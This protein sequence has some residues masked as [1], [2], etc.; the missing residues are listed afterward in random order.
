[1]A[2]QQTLMAERRG[3]VTALSQTHDAAAE[4]GKTALAEKQTLEALCRGEP[5][6]LDWAVT[7]YTPYVAAVISHVVGS[8]AVPADVEE[9]TSD[10]FV[11]LWQQPE[12]VRAGKLRPWLGAVARNKARDFLRSQRIELPLE[13]DLLS[14]ET[15][16]M[17]AS[18]EQGELRQAVRTAVFSMEQPDREIFIRHYYY[19]QPLRQVAEQMGMLESTVKTRLRRGR[20]ALKERLTQGGFADGIPNQ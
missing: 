5:S 11:A 18:T 4:K 15:D 17:Q 16:P 19:L 2:G 14:L 3:R 10:V 1:M 8:Y 9:L 6:A 20:L 13:D 7:R 12:R